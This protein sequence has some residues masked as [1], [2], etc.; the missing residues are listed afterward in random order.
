MDKYLDTQRSVIISS[1]AGSGKTEKLARRYIALLRE[2]VDIE[3]ILAITFTDKAATEMKERILRILRE[4]DDELFNKVIGRMS[5]MRVSTIH[6]FCGNILR[7]FSFEAG[8]DPNYRIVDSIDSDI[9]WDEIFDEV[10]MD[11]EDGGLLLRLIGGMGFR[12]RRALRKVM[13]YLFN[14]TPFSIEADVPLFHHNIPIEELLKWPGAKESID[15][16]EEILNGGRLDELMMIKGLFL[17]NK[18]EPRRRKPKELSRVIDYP[19]WAERMC[20][21]WV[22][23]NMEDAITRSMD[24]MEV[25]KRCIIRYREMKRERGF[26]D[27]SDLEYI[28]YK[29]LTEEPEWANILYAF[30][31]KTDH[32]LV[33]EFQDTNDFQWAIIDKLTEEWRSGLGPKRERGI[34]PTIFLVGDEKQSIFFFRGA[35][36]EVFH[37]AKR[38]LEEW[39]GDEFCYEE[40]RENFRSLPA[41]IDFTNH[42]F[43]KVMSPEEDAPLW[44]AAYSHFHPC[45]SDI[46]DSGRGRVELIIHDGDYKNMTDIKKN[47]AEILS[48]RILGIV[49]NME[50]FDRKESVRRRCR[51]EDI[52]ILLRKRTH[53]R[54]YE[55]ALRRYRIPFVTV[56]GIGFY[57]EPE[58]AILRALTYFLSNPADD[59]SLYVLLKSPF[60]MIDDGSIIRLMSGNGRTL[61]TKLRD[62]DALPN[63]LIRA[64][65]H[66]EEW[67]SMTS[68][69]P[70]SELIEA[71]LIRTGAWRYFHEPQR[72]ANIKKFIRIIE[73]LEADGRSLQKIRDFLERTYHKEE[74]SKANVNTE[75]MDAVKI[76]TIHSA[77]GLEFPIVFIP[78]LEERFRQKQQESLIYERDGHFYFKSITDPLIRKMDR[79]FH[80]HLQKEFEEEKRLLYV[81][82]TRAQDA[83]FLVSGWDG[84]DK[85]S[86]MGFIRDAIGLRDEG[87]NLVS[88]A[89]IDGFYIVNDKDVD[90]AF[91]NRALHGAEKVPSIRP[92]VTPLPPIRRIK[93]ATVTEVM[94]IRSRHGRGW[95][96]LGDLFHR[97]F[98]EV[99]KGLVDE[100]NI[101]KRIDEMLEDEGIVM[102]K[103]HTLSMIED[104]ISLLKERSIWQEIILPRKDSFTELPFIMEMDGTVYSGR[105]DRII[106]ECGEFRIYDYK[107]FPVKEGEIDYLLKEYSPQL[108]IYKE[109]IKRIFNVLN[110]KTYIVFT[111][112]GEIRE[113]TCQ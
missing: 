36:V 91:N 82:M 86:F 32:I 66:I 61:F 37:K 34:K 93:W 15:G 98:E 51:F 101:R 24:L 107:T 22:M 40:V 58:I 88:D 67:Q 45:R 71:A 100:G 48:K 6:S 60:F 94:D 70:L 65:D 17:T 3:R 97:L 41:I 39:L 87:G 46:P 28:T 63:N 21:L 81:A 109:A 83:L 64:L 13:G 69:L 62:S 90:R 76:I 1:P 55:D 19:R 2:G 95:L 103:G 7:R 20:E 108:A 74:E 11:P 92:V 102:D 23:R 99:S 96:M 105:I 14:K 85:Q 49:G 56:K 75:G 77:K 113:I 89:T 106:R 104:T 57:Q 16:Y 8:V 112:I 29:V 73:G 110:V 78:G 79:D 5:L 52:A 43:R 59:Y 9:A 38:R 44:K 26:L 35:N 47:E 18:G 31:E 84:D 4:E 68:H 111:Y 27:Y 12:G 53:L 72:R 10:L 25:F 30:D 33:D 54:R 80:L 42:I 50:I